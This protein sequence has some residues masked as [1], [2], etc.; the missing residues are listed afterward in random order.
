MSG[1]SKEDAEYML[2]KV[3]CKQNKKFNPLLFKIYEIL[4]NDEWF[5]NKILYSEKNLGT[6]AKYLGIDD[7]EDVKE[8]IKRLIYE[9]NKIKKQKEKTPEQKKSEINKIYLDAFGL[10]QEQSED[11]MKKVVIGRV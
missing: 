9:I 3:A 2:I 8:N 10:N 7:A 1:L 4:E 5:F 6:F 11:L